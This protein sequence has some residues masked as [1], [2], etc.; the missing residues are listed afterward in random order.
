VVGCSGAGKTTV[1]RA[2]A[3]RLGLRHI[4]LDALYHLPQWQ[5]RPAD[6]LRALVD[7]RTAEP[8]WVVDGNYSTVADLTWARAGTIV[9]L[10]LPRRTVMWQIVWRTFRR[11]ALRRELW[12]G[13]RERWRNFFSWK[14]EESIIRWA[15]TR[16]SK[17]RDRY[18][19]AIADPRWAHVTFVVL[20]N[21]RAV[22]RFLGRLPEQ[23]GGVALDD[24][25]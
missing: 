23:L 22:R 4:E 3:A 2:L 17:Y 9:V 13:N 19:T 16:Y 24:R 7:A 11:A 15:W 5:P 1:A 8:G 25:Q 10:D 14:P 6:E 12:S 21:R 18:R 20:R